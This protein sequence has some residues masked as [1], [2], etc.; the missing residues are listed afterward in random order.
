MT[1]PELHLFLPQMRM[2][3]DAIVERARNAEAAGFTGIAFMDHLAPP[4]AEDQSMYDAIA[5]ATW[6]AS[7]TETLTIGHLVL[8]DGFRHP[9]VLA[10]QAVTIDHASGGRFE[11][12]IGWG[13]V[14][15][16][17]ATF[18]VADPT[19]RVRVARFGETL[20]LLE[21]FWTG[22]PVHF[23][24]EFFTVDGGQQRP[25][26]TRR[27]PIV[28]GGAGPKT[29]AL[30]AK[31]AD[32]WNV[33]INFV[34]KFEEMADRRGSARASLQQMIAFVPEES[35]RTE[36]TELAHRR[37]GAMGVQVGNASELLDQYGDLA[38][39]GVERFYVWFA[40]FA[41]PET[42][43]AFGEQVIRPLESA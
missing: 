13:S 19:P 17:L 23:E 38:G 25:V 42:L 18:D 40:D 28:I 34:H 5:T 33:P 12:G 26:P 22:E 27:I 14:P 10:K 2:E 31:H 21:A 6:V 30:V 32:W 20:Q 16:E 9:A 15:A 24:G 36:I 3:L 35:R 11:L 4:M 1:V 41:A 39:R 8:C 7:R 43:A 37:F 29:M